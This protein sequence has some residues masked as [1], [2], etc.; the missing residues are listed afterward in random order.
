MI[1]DYMTGLANSLL[2]ITI[3]LAVFTGLGRGLYLSERT[4]NKSTIPFKEENKH[5]DIITN[6]SKDIK[7][8]NNNEHKA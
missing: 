5:P 7:N 4:K 2:V 6:P 1:L 3:I 8:P